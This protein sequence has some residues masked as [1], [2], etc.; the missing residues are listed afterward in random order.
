MEIETLAAPGHV[1]FT[2]FCVVN[3]QA[4]GVRGQLV[5]TGP[6]AQLDNHLL[7]F[8]AGQPRRRAELPL[9]LASGSDTPVDV[10]ATAAAGASSCEVSLAWRSADGGAGT[11]ASRTARWDA[12]AADCIVLDAGVLE[13]NPFHSITF[14]H[15]LAV[16]ADGASG[17][18]FRLLCPMPLR[19]EYDDSSSGQLLAIDANGNGNFSDEGDLHLSNPSGVAAAWVPLALPRSAVEIHLFALTGEPL[20]PAPRA[21]VLS[22]EAWR[23]GAWTKAAEDVLE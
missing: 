3:P 23:D 18:A 16:P 22:A 19:V 13:A 12:A 14:T 21:I 8:Q 4:A 15:Q 2:R 17:I 20:F 5:A 10:A 6:G 9:S 11:A 1:A 7:R